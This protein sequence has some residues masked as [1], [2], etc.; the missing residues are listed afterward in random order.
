MKLDAVEVKIEEER[1]MKLSDGFNAVAIHHGHLDGLIGRLMALCDLTGDLEQRRALKQE[2][3]W[4]CRDWL[5]DNY[6]MAGYSDNIVV[7]EA[8]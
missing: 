1:L 8:K 4:R 5:D 3:K 6:Q 2:I 7:G